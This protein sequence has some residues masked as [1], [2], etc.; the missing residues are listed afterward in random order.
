MCRC[1][2]ALLAQ[3]SVAKDLQIPMIQ[4]IL[5]LN[6]D[7]NRIY[8]TLSAFIYKNEFM[9]P[10]GDPPFLDPLFICDPSTP[11]QPD[12]TVVGLQ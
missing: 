1:H 10:E 5:A 11:T 3:I 4:Q 7:E 12:L 2:K 6:K 9:C 8:L